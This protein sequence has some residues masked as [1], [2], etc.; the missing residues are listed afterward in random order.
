MDREQKRAGRPKGSRTRRRRHKLGRRELD[1]VSRGV[2]PLEYALSIMRDASL[3][4]HRRDKMAMA[5]MPY[6]HAKLER[7][8]KLGKKDLLEIAAENAGAGTEW[9]ND[10]VGPK[11]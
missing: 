6:C 4:V 7:P 3:D 10:L 8:A 9:G 1:A 2:T 11:Q 5:A